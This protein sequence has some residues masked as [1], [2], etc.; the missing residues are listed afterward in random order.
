MSAAFL[1]IW[2]WPVLLALVTCSGLLS[3]LLSD[4]WGD[5]WS[6]FALGSPVA[7]S[8]WYAVPRRARAVAAN[9]P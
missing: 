3:A 8:V 1:R 6:W 5:V 4:G 9:S 7:L 2:G